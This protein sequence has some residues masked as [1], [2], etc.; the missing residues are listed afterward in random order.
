MKNGND[1]CLM[2]YPTSDLEKSKKTLV[3]AGAEV[4]QDAMGVGCGLLIARLKDVDGNF[5]GLRQ[6]TT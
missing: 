3:A 5:L 4:V 6:S 1:I 2:V